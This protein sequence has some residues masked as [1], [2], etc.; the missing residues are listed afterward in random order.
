MSR[1]GSLSPAAIAAMLSPDAGEDLIALL[2]I[3]GAGIVTPIR[4]ANAG[5]VRLSDTADEV[6]YGVVSRSNNFAFVPFRISLPD[7]QVASAPRATI[8]IDDVTQTLMPTIRSITTAPSVL[9]EL[10]LS[11]TP[12][13]LEV[14]FPGFLMG[15]ISY[16]ATQVTAEL[17]V[18]S[19]ASE[20]FPAHNF[21]PSYFPGLF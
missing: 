5:P 15:S 7:E 2:T 1:L 10:V 6:F 18:K 9:I 16:S 4:I 3:T 21:T 20:P 19:L 11:S 13:T 12:N 8:A 17:T 14:S